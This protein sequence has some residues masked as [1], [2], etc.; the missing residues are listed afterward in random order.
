MIKLLQIIIIVCIVNNVFANNKSK[1][2]QGY[3]KQ[4][5][6]S[7]ND[8]IERRFYL[9]EYYHSLYDSI[10]TSF[11]FETLQLPQNATFDSDKLIFYWTPSKE[12]VGKHR[13]KIVGKYKDNI[14]TLETTFDITNE[15]NSTLIPG[16]SYTIYFPTDKNLGAFKGVAINYLLSSWIAVNEY[17][18]PSH[19][20]V[21]TKFAI[22]FSDKENIKELFLYGIGFNVSFEKNAQ[23]NFLIPYFGFEISGI[24]HN[25]MSHVATFSPDVGLWFYYTENINIGGNFS[26]LFPIKYFETI[27]GYQTNITVTFS[28]W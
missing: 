13:F 25:T 26:Y 5:K 16:L 23:R 21:Y 19:G 3:A 22:L 20:N 10:K 28:L 24:S 14:D 12:D 27:R 1:I 9:T 6:Y 11:K 4:F 2:F 18:G 7:Y 17:P 15:W 8:I